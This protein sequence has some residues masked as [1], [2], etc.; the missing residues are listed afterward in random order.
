MNYI[1]PTLMKLYMEEGKAA[2]QAF[3][4]LGF[5]NPQTKEHIIKLKL[6]DIYVKNEK[7]IKFLLEFNE[8][9]TFF[10]ITL[11]NSKYTHNDEYTK[12]EKKEENNIINEGEDEYT[13]FKKDY[14][15]YID[16]K[17]NVVIS[18][19]PEFLILNIV[20]SCIFFRQAYPDLYFKD[21]DLLKNLVNFG[22]IYS[23]H[24]NLIHNQY[25]RSQIFDILLYSFH[26][27]EKEKNDNHLLMVHQKLLKDEYIKENLILSIMRVFIDAERLGTSNQFYERFNVRNKVLQLVN[28]V[29]KKNKEIL[30]DNIINYANHYSDN[31]TQMLTLLMGD[32]TYLI[33][34]V[35]QRLIDIRN[36]Q[37]LKDNKELWDSKTQEQKTEEDNKFAEN[38]RMLKAECRLLNHSLGFMTIICSCL[39]KYFIKEEKAERLADLMNYCLDE[40]TAKSSQLKIK[41]K[42]DYEFN[43]SYIME[44]IIKIFSYF[45]N[46]EEFLEYVVSDPRAY[47]YDNFTKAIKL[48]NENK[49]KVDMETSENFDNLVYNKLK[50]AEELVEQKKINY[51]DAPEEYLDPLTYDL[52]ENPVILP[53]S[54]INIDRRTIED[55]LLTNPSDP[56]NR[57][58]LTKEEL[59]P[60]D[61]LKKKIDEY[62]A[63]KLKE[64]QKKLNKKDDDIKIKTN[65]TNNEEKKEEN[66]NEE[67]KDEAI[68]EEKK[69]GNKDEN[70]KEENK[71]SQNKDENNAQE[72]NEEN[73]IEENKDENNN[74]ESKNE[75]IKDQNNTEESK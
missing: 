42:N 50:K 61:D 47:K 34:E 19:L 72:K 43:P 67:I 59:I 17:S 6:Y 46:Y 49:V 27:E 23:S 62:K 53:S 73:K 58:P 9:T 51:D 21:F 35:I 11:N 30:I 44:S 36:Y 3:S 12:E 20:N 40:F 26:L 69:E 38:D 60:N 64:K 15:K 24:I 71:I 1:I 5:N 4:T 74:E 10:L 52:M 2:S 14:F 54:H 33:D 31:A 57:N 45:V 22:L 32:V 41:N 29:F 16:V 13:L 63:K 70:N 48:K 65:E 7:F 66:K 39:Q 25:L 55:Y 28:E 8:I 56:F 18:S 75:E 37:E 68:I